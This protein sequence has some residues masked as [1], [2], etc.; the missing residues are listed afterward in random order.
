MKM[1]SFFY[2]GRSLNY[3]I[4]TYNNGN[5]LV[6]GVFLG[7]TIDS[8]K[9]NP[10]APSAI[11]V[12]FAIANSSKYLAIPASYSEEIMAVIGASADIPQPEMK[13]LLNEW[14][15]YTKDNHVDRRIRH[16]ITGN[17]LQAF[18]DFKGK[19]VS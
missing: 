3:P 19:L 16:I 4:E 11:K 15:L 1:F 6:P 8:K 9:K 13:E 10:Y 2:V 5:E 14:D 7:F 12:R 17:L 18:S